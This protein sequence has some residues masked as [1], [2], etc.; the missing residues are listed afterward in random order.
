MQYSKKPF[1]NFGKK[2]KMF[3]L[4]TNKTSFWRLYNVDF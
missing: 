1:E 4:R 3:M 2:K